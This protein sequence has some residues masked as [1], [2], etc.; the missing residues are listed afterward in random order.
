MTCLGNFIWIFLGGFW[1]FIGWGLTGIIWC[2][3][4][5]GIPIGLQCFKIARLS[6]A[7]F[8]KKIIHGN[9][10]HLILNLLWIIFGGFWLALGHLISAGFLAL[11]IIG[12][13]FALQQLK[14]ARLAILPFG[15]KI[16][17]GDDF[18]LNFNLKI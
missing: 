8:G 17:D 6:F 9:E 10:F 2:L 15:A 11:T 1:N 4:I 3:T 12:I 13:P 7:P 5:V 18:R 16:I 14:M